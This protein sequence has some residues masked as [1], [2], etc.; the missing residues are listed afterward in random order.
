M[1]RVSI[2][3]HFPRKDRK[4]KLLRAGLRELKKVWHF[5]SQSIIRFEGF[6]VSEMVLRQKC[7]INCFDEVRKNQIGIGYGAFKKIVASRGCYPVFVVENVL[8]LYRF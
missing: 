6:D 7:G 1:F 8:I 2:C 3:E 4:K 5:V